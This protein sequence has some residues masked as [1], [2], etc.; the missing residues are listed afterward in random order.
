MQD[1]GGLFSEIRYYYICASA[2]DAVKRFHHR[3][4]PVEQA[5]FGGGAEHHI[6]A[7]YIIGGYGAI[8]SLLSAADDIQKTD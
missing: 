4:V 3:G 2:F 8:E 1:S 7:A 6:L 5:F